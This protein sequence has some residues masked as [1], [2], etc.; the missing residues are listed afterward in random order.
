M[1][2]YHN[3]YYDT[4]NYWGLK[5]NLISSEA[6]LLYLFIFYFFSFCSLGAAGS[7]APSSKPTAAADRVGRH[8]FM[9]GILVFAITIANTLYRI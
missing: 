6:K 1:Y 2:C 4:S 8:V 9:S 5:G 7:P 3:E